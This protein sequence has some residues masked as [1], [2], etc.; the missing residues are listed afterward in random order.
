[1]ITVNNVEITVHALL[2][3]QPVMNAIPFSRC[4]CFVC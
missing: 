2:H 3:A 4:L 1:M